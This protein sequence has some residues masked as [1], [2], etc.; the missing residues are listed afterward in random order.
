MHF[1][2]VGDVFL[3]QTVNVDMELEDYI[4]NLEYPFSTEGLPA[5]NKVNLGADA[6]FFDQTFQKNKP[7][8]VNLANNHI[9]DYGESGFSKT[10]EYLDKRKIKYFGAGNEK[11]NYNNPL[12]IQLNTKKIALFGYSCPTTHPVFGGKNSNGSAYLDE[13]KI[14]KDICKFKN[15][16]DMIII[17]LH[18]GDEE[19]KYP[20][21]SD[22][23][24]A[25]MFIDAGADMIIGHHAH[26]IQSFEKYK[27]K[28]IFYGLGNFIFPDF[29]VP[30]YHNGEKFQK[31]FSK[32][33]NRLNKQGLLVELNDKLTVSYKTTFFNGDNVR[34]KNV[35]LPKWIP[36]VQMHYNMYYKFWTKL[37]MLELYCKNPRIPSGEQIKLFFKY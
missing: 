28:Y 20:T 11:N 6:S 25:R 5:T 17:N 7:I 8:A 4:L 19:I 9:M 3:D 16:S 37:R 33:Q 23:N 14:L 35:N 2:F 29:E 10:I 15:T 21:P 22:V 36:K 27:G 24:K 31:S 32:R 18:W 12:I 26:V 1:T 34:I 13:T 30:A